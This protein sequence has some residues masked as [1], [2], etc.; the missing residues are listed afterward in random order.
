MKVTA[1]TLA[2][3][4]RLAGHPA[5]VADEPGAAVTAATGALYRLPGGSQYAEPVI[6]GSQ[7]GARL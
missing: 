3:V 5:A 2:E 4:R 7:R 6:S 1:Q